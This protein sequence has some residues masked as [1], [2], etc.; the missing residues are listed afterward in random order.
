M[1]RKALVRASAGSDPNE[2]RLVWALREMG[3]M[4]AGLPGF[5]GKAE[6]SENLAEARSA[7]CVISNCA[8]G[9]S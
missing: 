5:I 6:S 1:R 3:P 7:R 2:A 4:L 9:L 8:D